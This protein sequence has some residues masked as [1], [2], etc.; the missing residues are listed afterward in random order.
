[1]TNLKPIIEARNELFDKRNAIFEAAIEE[2]RALTADE[3][4]EAQDLRDQI[5]AYDATVEESRKTKKLTVTQTQDGTVVVDDDAAKKQAADIKALSDYIR[6]RKDT[7]ETDSVLNTASQMKESGNSAVIPTTIADK[8]VEKV[9]EISPIYEKATKY[10]DPGDLKI[11]V[12]DT[13]TDDVTIGFVADELDAPDSHVPAFSSITLSGYVY[14]AIALISKKLI[15]NAQFDIVTWLVNYLAKKIAIFFEAT[16]IG[17]AS[18]DVKGIIGSY[19]STNMKVVT[20]N[21]STITFDELIK[22]KAKVPT[23]YQNDACF[24][25]NSSTY[26]AITLLKDANGRYLLQID[27]TAP[28]GFSLLGKPVYLTENLGNLGT[29]SANLI[30]YGDFSGLAVKEPGAFEVEVL[31]ERYSDIGAVG[32]N[33]WGE[34]DSKVEDKQKI[35]VMAAHAS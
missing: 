25:M 17:S 2:S 26:E 13:S 16:L 28:F 24:V 19:D 11:T 33:L 12:V 21:K 6:F 18:A 9:K 3:L 27:P 1:M 34:I 7:L 15:R 20:A 32:I 10:S 22:L 5:D 23:A 30:I 8:I 31:Y 29:A 35:A 4:K 14:R